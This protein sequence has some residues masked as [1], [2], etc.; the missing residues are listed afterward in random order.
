M[1]LAGIYPS[2]DFTNSPGIFSKALSLILERNSG[3]PDS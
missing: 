3:R 1:I 2:H